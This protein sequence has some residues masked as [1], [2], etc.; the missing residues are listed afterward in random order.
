MTR[1]GWFGFICFLS[2]FFF[3][4]AV[5]AGDK[6]PPKPKPKPPVKK[7]APDQT[8]VRM[9]R[10]LQKVDRLPHAAEVRAM[11]A[12]LKKKV[13]NEEEAADKEP[14]AGFT[15]GKR[16]MPLPTKVRQMQE[17]LET[18]SLRAW[19]KRFDPRQPHPAT[20]TPAPS[21]GPGIVF[22]A[23]YSDWGRNLNIDSGCLARSD[24]NSQVG[25]IYA[26]ALSSS[27][28]SYRRGECYT[29]MEQAF[30]APRSGK[31]T[32]KIL[33]QNVQCFVTCI[34][35]LDYCNQSNSSLWGFICQP[36]TDNWQE[37]RVELVKVPVPVALE[38]Y[39][40]NRTLTLPTVDVQKGEALLLGAGIRQYDRSRYGGASTGSCM[41]RVWRI[42]VTIQ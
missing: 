32:V 9:K 19:A 38:K 15:S 17:T 23:P 24:G 41:A 8:L 1:Q 34:Q 29:W 36:R 7:P 26:D 39:F 3:A 13:E 21:A 12:S 27:T 5:T 16:A 10:R 20:N 42:V 25:T 18:K 35:L 14:P 11:F 30:T 33:Y 31:M 37:H 4:A 40:D 6:P 28:G 2:L 22:K